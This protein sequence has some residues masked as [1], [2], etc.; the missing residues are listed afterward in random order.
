MAF[1]LTPAKAIVGVVDYTTSEGRKIFD[2][3]VRRLD[4]DGTF[5]CTP[6][7]LNGFL[8]LVSKRAMDQ[9]WDEEANGVIMIPEDSTDP[10]SVR[11]HLCK[12]YG[13]I[14]IDLIREYEGSYVDQQVRQAQDA[15][16]LYTCLMN[17]LSAEGKD[18]VGVWEAQYTAA[19]L[20]SG[21]LLLKVI[22]RESHLDTNATTTFI[23]TQLSGLDTYI[24][25]IGNDITMFNGHVK[26]LVEA[27]LARGETTND[28]LTNLFKGYEACSD[29]VFT[30][31]IQGKKDKHDEGETMSTDELM[32]YAN[33]KYKLLKQAKKWQAPSEEEE[34]ILALEAEVKTLKRKSK[35]PPK[36]KNLKGRNP[37]K[38]KPEQRQ[39]DKPSWF[40]TKPTK[41]MMSKPRMW[42]DKQ[43]WYCGKES[44]GKCAGVYRRH[45]PSQCEGKAF[46]FVDKDKGT[47]KGAGSEA[48]KQSNAAKKL[49]LS[50]ALQAI[51]DEEEKESESE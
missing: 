45:K 12:E 20:P 48:K 31:Y 18:K 23:R 13:S 43:W 26:T 32:E 19:N 15:Y 6:G 30:A 27:L 14:D 37:D 36:G 16:M 24:L 8:K 38:G 25:E 17:S 39:D 21:N 22:I 49:K 46:T 7:K 35:P 51:V 3:G 40:N 28:L 41:E 47:S 33:N 5:D 42:N 9:G 34:K 29:R 44:G 2:K 4:E 10:N 50:A 1:A 11:H